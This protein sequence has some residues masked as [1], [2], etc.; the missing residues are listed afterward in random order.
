MCQTTPTTTARL[1]YERG[2]E[3]DFARLI[4]WMVAALEPFCAQSLRLER[5]GV[6]RVLFDI[7]HCR[8]SLALQPGETGSTGRSDLVVAVGA[9]GTDLAQDAGPFHPQS[10]CSALVEKIH[11][12]NPCRAILWCE[13]APLPQAAGALE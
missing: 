1:T 12:R 3:P 5:C 9:N 6:T 2:T 4:A 10:L 13:A 11:N 7:D 8:I